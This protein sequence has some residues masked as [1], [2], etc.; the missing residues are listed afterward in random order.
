MAIIFDGTQGITTPAE[1]A[2]NSVTT[3]IVKSSANLVFQSNG[4]TEAMRIDSSGNLN[5]GA[6]SNVFG[7]KLGITSS[8]AFPLAVITPSIAGTSLNKNTNGAGNHIL[9]TSNNS[10]NYGVIG[11]TSAD[12]TS[13]GDIFTLGYTPSGGAAATNVLNWSSAG[14][15]TMPAQ[16]GFRAFK[17]T[18][19]TGP[20]TV[21]FGSTQFNTGNHYSTSTGRF[22][23]PVAGQY[24][25]TFAL[26][27]ATGYTGSYWAGIKLNN[28]TNIAFAEIDWP[29]N[30]RTLSAS[31]VMQMSAGDFVTVQ[32]DLG[33]TYSGGSGEWNNFSGYLLG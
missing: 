29:G 8:A 5:I 17:T 14:R 4:T 1:T 20:T 2:N 32:L 18:G 24:F 22:T 7:S 15:V 12:G 21:V 33:Q 25:F 13:T 3:P 6:P 16:P 31:I 23:A 30:Y 11:V 9:M 26:L 28:A 27:G 10:F 19:D